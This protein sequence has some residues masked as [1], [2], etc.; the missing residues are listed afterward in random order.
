MALES[1]AIE[2]LFQLP[3]AFNTISC[4]AGSGLE[5]ATFG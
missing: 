3:K 5:P 4:G 1:V 2:Q